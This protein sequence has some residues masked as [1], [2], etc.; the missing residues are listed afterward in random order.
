M[1][2][3]KSLAKKWMVTCPV[4]AEGLLTRLCT[5]GYKNTCWFRQ[6]APNQ[7][8]WSPLTG[9]NR[10]NWKPTQ[11]FSCRC[12]ILRGLTQTREGFISCEI[13]FSPLRQIRRFLENLHNKLFISMSQKLQSWNQQRGTWVTHRAAPPQ[14]TNNTTSNS[15]SDR[16]HF[17]LHFYLCC[18]RHSLSCAL[19]ISDRRQASQQRPPPPPPPPHSPMQCCIWALCGEPAPGSSRVL[20]GQYT[21]WQSVIVPE[22]GCGRAP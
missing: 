21:S 2:P 19:S 4:Y 11:P 3:N 22:G 9:S 15:F 6:L 20:P 17:S 7:T 5:A 12:I 8:S 1:L 13:N 18:R 14:R 10:Q 16:S